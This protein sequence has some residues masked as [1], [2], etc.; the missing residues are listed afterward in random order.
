M[1]SLFN[2]ESFIENVI[3]SIND[4]YKFII[5]KNFENIKKN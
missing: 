1:T 3:K 2:N 5:N 4:K